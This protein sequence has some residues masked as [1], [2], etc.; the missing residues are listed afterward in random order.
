MDDSVAEVVALGDGVGVGL[1]DVGTVTRPDD[2]SEPCEPP[3]PQ[4]VSAARA[5]TSGDEIAAARNRA[6][7]SGNAMSSP[8]RTFCRTNDLSCDDLA[9]STCAWRV[10]LWR[11]SAKVIQP[12]FCFFHVLSIYFEIPREMKLPP[13]AGSK[14][15][16]TQKSRMGTLVFT[17]TLYLRFCESGNQARE[18]NAARAAVRHRTI[19]PLR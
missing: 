19:I 7:F 10:S 9:L 12:T 2:K 3:P 18:T 13:V 5:T 14:I 1:G 17:T 4:P 16:H 15:Q 11:S 8:C 6:D